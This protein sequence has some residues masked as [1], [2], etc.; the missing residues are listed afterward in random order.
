MDPSRSNVG[1][2]FDQ[3]AGS[4][5]FL[6]HLLSLNI[7]RRWRRL[8]VN[9]LR[10]IHPKIILDVATGTADLALEA[11]R[12]N[13]HKITGV[14]LSEGMLAIG[15][16]KVRRK[17]LE[18]VIELVAGRSE[19]L[20]FDDHVFDATMVAFGVRNFEDPLKGLQEMCRVLRS[21]GRIVVLEFT[22]PGKG[23]MRTLYRLYFH[24]ILPS[25]GKLFS[26]NLDAYR[27][28]PDSVEH[29]PKGREFMDLMGRAGFSEMDF[30]SMTLGICG[31]YTATK[32]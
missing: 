17:N 14:D 30:R 24:R 18:G 2:M 21:G 20:P 5:D 19:E 12:L 32:K 1:D 3:I 11:I 15:K 22:L 25:I 27:Y 23:L 16:E 8:A 7:D 28:L 31:L 4:Y 26:K 6:N 9:S 29:F 10:P 13:P